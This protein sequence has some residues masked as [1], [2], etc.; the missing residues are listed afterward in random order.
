MKVNTDDEK[1]ADDNDVSGRSRASIVTW[2]VLERAEK[3]FCPEG[4]NERKRGR[5]GRRQGRE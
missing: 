3:V 5:Q 1:V 4:M 2:I